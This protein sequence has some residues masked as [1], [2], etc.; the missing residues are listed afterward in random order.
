MIFDF[1]YTIILHTLI[2]FSAWA[3][4]SKILL[5]SWYKTEEKRHLVTKGAVAKSEELFIASMQLEKQSEAIIMKTRRDGVEKRVMEREKALRQAD[6]IRM[7]ADQKAVKLQKEMEK[8]LLL[9]SKNFRIH[10]QGEL[11]ELAERLTD[12]ILKRDSNG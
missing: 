7:A 1:D 3:V 8:K 4:V 10:A 6:K 5:K 11:D 12:K 9:E 2:F